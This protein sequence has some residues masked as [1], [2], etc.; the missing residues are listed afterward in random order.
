[1][2]Q[3]EA[4]ELLDNHPRLSNQQINELV[5]N[6]VKTISPL[7]PEDTMAVLAS[8]IAVPIVSVAFDES[9]LKQVRQF[10]CTRLITQ[11]LEVT[12][13]FFHQK[14]ADVIAMPETMQ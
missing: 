8:V 5:Y 3:I 6:L 13:D 9:E 10:V 2:N 4:Q 1:M 11:V 7:H 14:M 12:D